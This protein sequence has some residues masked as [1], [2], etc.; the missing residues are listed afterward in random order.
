MRNSEGCRFR[1][2]TE[3]HSFCSVAEIDERLRTQQILGADEFFDCE[4]MIDSN[5]CPFFNWKNFSQLSP[6]ELRNLATR[7][8]KK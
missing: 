7:L 6:T 3:N 4:T 5:V 8:I 1:V 2:E